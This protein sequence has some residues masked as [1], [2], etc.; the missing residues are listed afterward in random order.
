MKFR[1]LVPANL[2]VLALTA[3]GAAVAAQ[4][5]PNPRD[6]FLYARNDTSD[7]FIYTSNVGM[8]PVDGKVRVS[9]HAVKKVGVENQLIF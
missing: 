4:P 5:R 1:N 9:F 6:E 7:D 2:A 8:E 3:A